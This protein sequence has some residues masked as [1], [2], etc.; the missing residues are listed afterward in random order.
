[1]I[2]KTMNNE[3]NKDM[4]TRKSYT[5][6]E[7]IAIMKKLNGDF[8]PKNIKAVAAANNTTVQNLRNWCIAN[9][10]ISKKPYGPRKQ[11]APKIITADMIAE[12]SK[13]MKPHSK[14]EQALVSIKTRMEKKQAELEKLQVEYSEKE[15][16]F[17]GIQTEIQ[18]EI[19]MI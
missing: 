7:K 9:G 12:F 19:G 5:K 6:A 17:L 11:T 15:K 16:E 18:K 14:K 8:S 4:T 10:L 2:D 3:N 1:M 13:R